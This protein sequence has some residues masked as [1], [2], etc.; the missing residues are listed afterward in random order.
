MRYIYT[1][2][3]TLS[4]VL[5]SFDAGAQ[6]SALQTRYKPSFTKGS[7]KKYIRDIEQQTHIPVSYSNGYVDVRRVVQLPEMEVTIAEALNIILAGQQVTWQQSGDKILLISGAE[8]RPAA[9]GKITV[10]GYVKELQNREVL[11]GA[12]VYVPELGIG[13]TTNSYGFYSLTMPVGKYKIMCSYIGYGTDSFSS[14]GLAG[15]RKDIMLSS[16]SQL[17]EVKVVSEKETSAEHLH[18]TY[19]DIKS[20]PTVLGE[21]D[22]MRALQHISG[23][24]SGTDGT[25]AV[26]VRGG[27]PG[28]NLNLLDGVPLYY[29]DHFFGFTSIYNAE[30]IKSVDFHKGAFPSRY[31]GRLSSVIDVNT[32]D[33]DMQRWGGQFTMGLVK[34]SINLEGPLVKD[35]ASIM[36]SGRRTWFDLLWKPFTKDAGFNFYDI[37]GKANYILNKNNRLYLSVYNGRDGIMLDFEGSGSK[38]RWGNTVASAKW[39]TI[40]NPKLFVNTI[41]TFSQFKYSLIDKKEQIDKDGKTTTGTYQGNSSITDWALRLH[42]NWYATA[43]Q[44]IEFGAHFSTASFIPAEMLTINSQQL[45]PT[46]LVPADK[47]QSNEYSVF[48]EDEVRINKR[49]MIRPGIHFAN[50]FSERFNY[51]SVQP[52]FYTSYKLAKAHTVYASYTEMAQFLHLISNTTFGLPTDF[53]IPSSSRIEPEEATLYTV[54]Y[55]G[56]PSKIGLTYNIEGYY[57]DITNTTTY[58]MGKNL[59]DNSLKWDEKIIQGTG[60]SYGAEASFKKKL[61]SFTW[62]AAYTLSWTWRKFA[63]LNEGKPFPYRFDRRHNLKTTLEYHPSERFDVAAS[64]SYMTGE[65][66][67][68]PDQIYPDLDNNLHITSTNAVNS[69]N[70]TYNYVEWNNYRLPAIH[71]LDIGMNF[72]KR[73]GKHYER[74]WSLGVFN[75]YARRNI[76]YVELVNAT[77]DASNGDFKLRGMSF[78]QFIPYLSYKLAF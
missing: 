12:V 67:T 68:L 8:G 18:L 22:V 23:V 64:W 65:A 7:V 27:D 69:A 39:N 51:S 30:A 41:V 32:K 31:G 78:L 26:M 34:G 56:R 44:R 61:G 77:G 75:A 63:Q 60:W 50:W 13:T 66:I 38:A 9:S 70:Y 54:G 52:R 6:G 20:R 36:V 46:S 49:W 43:T 40:V 4:V 3:L 73:K 71:R 10:N 57:K 21:N 15:G 58:N 2:L 14:E 72:T 37:N 48:I 11:I 25:N 76:M 17:K 53:W 42:A 62:A 19:A 29:T 16:L 74:T 33:G 59:F 24:Q 5:A 55:M 1:L 45:L 47:F 28:Q 35:K